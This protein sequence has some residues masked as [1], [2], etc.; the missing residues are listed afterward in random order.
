MMMKDFIIGPCFVITSEEKK[1][2]EK[3]S[4]EKAKENKMQV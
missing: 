1:R 3:E 2:G 4:K